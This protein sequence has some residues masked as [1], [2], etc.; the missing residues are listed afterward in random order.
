[1]AYAVAER[2]REIGIRMALGARARDIL[3]MVSRHAA[4]VIGI[5]T[6]LG[7]AGALALTKVMQS[8]LFGVTTT[9]PA[10]YAA[11]SLLLLLIAAVA[12]L[13]PARRAVSVDPAVTLKRDT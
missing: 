1:M 6:V 2:T 13:I 11:G 12:S 5:G 4:G 9:D 3:L 8:V 10:T 7:L